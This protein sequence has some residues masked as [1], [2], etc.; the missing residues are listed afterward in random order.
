MR[1]AKTPRPRSFL[2][3]GDLVDRLTPLDDVF[4]NL[5]RDELPMH[6][7]SL[8][9]FEGPVPRYD[10]VLVS[11]G[12]RLDR[13]PRYRQ[14]VR[15]VPL[16]LGQPIWVDDPHFHLPYHVRHTAVPAPG[17]DEEL[18]ALAGRLL[19]QRL[20]RDRPLWEFWLIEGLS[21]GRFAVLNKVHHAMIDGLSGNDLMET[22]L[23]L[24]A[25][26]PQPTASTWRP[27]PQPSQIQQIT[28]A[29]VDD[30]RR[31]LQRT[32]HLGELLREPWDAARSAAG[33]LVGAAR[34][35]RELTNVERHLIGKPT[36]H[37]R[38]AWAEG[39][40]GEVKAIKRRLGGTVNDVILTAVSGGFRAFLLGRGEPL[41]THD[42]VRSMVPV[43]TRA[44]GVP[45]G[46]NEVAVIFADLPI[47]IA[48]PLL[49][50][51]R[52]RDSLDEAKSSGLL[53][54]TDA[55]IENAV[56]VPPALL[57][58]AGKVAAHAPQPMVA[59]VT[60]NVPGPQQQLYLLGRP[61]ITL[62]PYVPLGMNQLVTVAIMSYNGGIACGI[63]AD[64]EAVPDV[65]V[66]ADGIEQ[67]LAELA[68]YLR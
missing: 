4:I 18:R 3:Y 26:P 33:A 21:D 49:R 38:W 63:T 27:E 54:G 56:F 32:G 6:I 2:G 5:E 59:T 30:V 64:Y 57:A 58:A 62:L 22:L 41:T 50:Y 13:I 8:L 65:Q 42:T 25:D 15:E 17:G 67:S 45:A 48:D 23:D 11:I 46:G 29:L 47:G 28:E 68:G 52:M 20:D 66:L 40:L 7:G 19:S 39:D 12:G 9:I 55:L 14:R 34:L 53:Q 36:P 16:R 10:D 24:T 43:S 61:L 37:R 44:P 35:G 1:R 51:Q 60:T 31:P